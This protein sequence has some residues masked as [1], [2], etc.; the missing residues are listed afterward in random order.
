MLER[1][2]TAQLLRNLL[3]HSAPVNLRWK[4]I[5]KKLAKIL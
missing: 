5:I 3:P 4:S 1:H 2:I